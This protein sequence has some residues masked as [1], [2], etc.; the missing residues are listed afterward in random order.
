MTS[1]LVNINRCIHCTSAL[2]TF[3]GN[4]EM[5]IAIVE[6]YMQDHYPNVNWNSVNILQWYN[7]EFGNTASQLCVNCIID[8]M[9]T[10]HDRYFKEIE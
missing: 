1:K 6:L 9:I 5:K 7:H 10:I 4:D 2:S 8:N 3:K